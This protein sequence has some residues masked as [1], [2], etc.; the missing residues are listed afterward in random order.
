M[1]MLRSSLSLSSLSFVL[2]LIL[3]FNIGGK[4]CVLWLCRIMELS[5]N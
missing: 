1:G 4:L 2:T 3:L 5:L